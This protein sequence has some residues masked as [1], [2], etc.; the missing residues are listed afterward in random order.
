[1]E[2]EVRRAK[3]VGVVHVEVRGVGD[4]HEFKEG[5]GG[6][7]VGWALGGEGGDGRR[8]GGRLREVERREIW[9][10]EGFKDR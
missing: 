8:D 7:K 1:L 9:G 5:K 4:V 2:E 10:G 3:E 6:Q